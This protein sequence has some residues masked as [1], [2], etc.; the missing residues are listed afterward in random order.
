MG[1][2]LTRETMASLKNIIK[3]ALPLLST[4]QVYTISPSAFAQIVLAGVLAYRYY[5]T[6]PMRDILFVVLFPT[7]LLLA[8][9]IRFDNNALIRQRAKEHPHN[10]NNVMSKFFSGSDAPWFI[11]KYMPTAVIIGLILPLITILVAPED[12][13]KLATPHLFVLWCQI[14]GESVTMFNPY[15]HRFV[16]LLLPIAFSVYRMSLLVEWVLWSISLLESITAIESMPIE[17]M[18]G[19]ALASLNLLFWSYN[20]FVT[21]LLRI[22]PEFLADEKCEAPEY[23]ISFLFIQE[24]KKEK[25]GAK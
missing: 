5:P 10:I 12:V 21:L 3:S 11:Q 24:D 25:V 22:T 20:L 6:I 4:S 1:T 7:Y 13:A 2:H 16:T 23:A 9:H 8:N 15:A 18:W 17:Y 14:I 19:L